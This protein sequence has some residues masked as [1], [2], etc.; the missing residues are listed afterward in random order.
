MET[1]KKQLATFRRKTIALSELE[2]LIEPP[3]HT[4]EDF[5]QRIIQL[6]EDKVLSMVKAKGR[7]NRTPSLAFQYRI[8]K[9]LL[10]EDYHKQL[11]S[12]RTTLHPLIDLDDYYSKDPAVF[13]NDLVFLSMID[14]YLRT[15]GLPIEPVP[16]PERSYQLAGDE[17][18]IVEKGGKEVLE[19]IKL[20]DAL[21]IIPVSEPLMFAVNPY[22]MQVADQ[23]HLVVENK[24]TY[25]G[26]LPALP[27]T[28]FSTLIYGSGKAVIKSIEQF[29]MQYPVKASHHFFYFGD[30]DK[31]GIAIW[32]HFHHKQSA[33]PALPFY[34]AC[35]QKTPAKGKVYQQE[36]LQALQNFLSYFSKAEEQQTIQALIDDGMYHPQ[37]TLKTKELQQIWRE[38]DWT[39]LI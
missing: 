23:Y 32:H 38:S 7:N 21:K 13:Q 34:L 25:Q 14:N 1:M 33:L 9:S 27:D 39:S 30:L 22:K 10:M 17:K 19:R 37:E 26:L 3:L 31:E 24:T 20:F 29:S 15:E 8:N 4:Y 28:M 5:A 18:W 12:Y 35:L 16:A 11:Q 6:E 2:Q 36:N